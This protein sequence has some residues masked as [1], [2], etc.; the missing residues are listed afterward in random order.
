VVRGS[1]LSVVSD[2]KTL[3][4]A[5]GSVTKVTGWE[6]GADGAKRAVITLTGEET[7]ATLAFSVLPSGDV[8]IATTCQRAQGARG[9][10][11]LHYTA[12]L[13]SGT[14]AQGAKVEART[15]NGSTV[16]RFIPVAPPK[17]PDL[18]PD[19]VLLPNFDTLSLNTR[20]GRLSVA[21]TGGEG[22][23][24][25]IDARASREDWAASFPVLRIGTPATGATLTPGTERTLTY[26][27][28]L[29]PGGILPPVAVKSAAAAKGYIALDAV[30]TGGGGAKPVPGKKSAR[31]A[32]PPKPVPPVKI[33]ASLPAPLLIPRPKKVAGLQNPP[34]VLNANTRIVVADRAIPEDQ[35]AA[36]LLKREILARVGLNLPVVKASEAPVANI[37]ILS[38]ALP[39]AKIWPLV[40]A[41]QVPPTPPKEEGYALAVRPTAVAI[42]GRDSRGVYWGAQTLLQLLVKSNQGPLIR[43]AVI[44]DWPTLKMRAVHL[45]HGKDAL[46]F[47]KALME[48]VLSRFKMNALFLEV[49]QVRWK[50]DPSVAPKWAGTPGQIQ[51]EIAFA[52]ERN[53]EVFPLLQSYGHLDG[54]L[55]TAKTKPF[56]EDPKSPFAL[57][58][59]DPNAMKYWE[60]FITEADATFQADGFHVGLDEVNLKGKGRYPYRSA[61]KTLPQLYNSAAGRWK[62]YFGRR[63]KRMFM[64]ADMALN[65]KEAAPSTG[66]A[67]TPA[68]AAAIR[69][70]LSK[71]VTLID[72]QYGEQTKFPSLTLLKNAGFRNLMGATWY[73]PKNI[74]NFTRAVVAAGGTGMVQTTWCGYESNAR[75]LGTEERRQFTAMVLAADYFWNGGAGPAPDKLP[76]DPE[77]VFTKC[78]DNPAE[79]AEVLGVGDSVPGKPSGSLPPAAASPDTQHPTPNTSTRGGIVYDLTGIGNVP[80]PDA[81]GY[82]KDNAPARLPKG[83]VRMADGALYRFGGKAVLLAGRLNP[84]G[85]AYPV[86]LPLPLPKN[87]PVQ[88][89]R[90]ALTASHRAAPGTKLGM[91]RVSRQD[92][93]E[94]TIDLVYGINCAAPDDETAPTETL[95]APLL[96]RGRT[97][98]GQSYLIRGLRYVNTQ[99]S[100]IT[101]LTLTSVTADSAP[102]LYGMTVI[103]Q[104][105]K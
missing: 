67:P 16:N 50:H 55:T 104:V 35:R 23:P 54:I 83:P 96:W 61:P 52:K 101:G 65:A 25:L 6:D 53:I 57:C 58:V 43:A 40:S 72:W 77:Q 69:A 5:A 44:E 99:R 42:V 9:P 59:S 100:P 46:P 82:G 86:R 27:F 78:W 34:F 2:G 11:T 92:G 89:V 88:E 47:H 10:A 103:T 105:M 74:A 24:T 94:E 17:S 80:L 4:D 76:Y 102:L 1:R 37:I 29:R 22:L 33:A 81:L 36:T 79:V 84:G 26:T 63:G 48:R 91:L 95:S 45:F 56:A 70:G 3:C 90:L 49:E 13:V 66:S 38:G 41:K 30:G 71:D 98:L 12:G 32:T 85:K 68:D 75:V 18:G 64:W 51:Q 15:G 21:Y 28:A 39:N 8:T 87:L 60:G 20:L 73:R 97:G 7:T 14:V 62:R 93:S 31:A 19:T